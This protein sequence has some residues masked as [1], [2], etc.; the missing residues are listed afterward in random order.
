MPGTK[1]RRRR[2]LVLIGILTIPL[3]LLLL[4]L[5]LWFP[6]LAQPAARSFGFEF[7]SYRRLGLTRFELTGVTGR[8]QN[9]HITVGR[10]ESF[11]PHRW[12]WERWNLSSRTN[13]YA[14][15]T[16]WSVQIHPRAETEPARPGAQSTLQLLDQLDQL[17][18]TLRSWMPAAQ[19]RRGKIHFLDRTAALPEV[20]W[21]VGRLTAR[22][23]APELTETVSVRL[24]AT[25]PGRWRTEIEGAA[26]GLNVLAELLRHPNAWS[27]KGALN[28]HSN[29]VAVTARFNPGAWL[30]VEAQLS[31]QELRLPPE[32]N[33]L[34][35]YGQCHGGFLLRWRDEAYTLKAHG[36]AE[37]LSS[38]TNQIWP[39][40]ELDLNAHGDLRSAMVD[41][42][43]VRAS[44]FTLQLKQPMTLAYSASIIAKPGQFEAN[45]NLDRL[46]PDWQGRLT[47]EIGVRP[48]TNHYP[49]IAIRMRSSALAA[50]GIHA[51]DL[52]ARASFDWPLLELEAARMFLGSN[53]TAQAHGVLDLQTR[54]LRTAVFE[55]QGDDLRQFLPDTLGVD[56]LTARVQAAGPLSHLSHHG[57]LQVNQLT[58]PQLNPLAL[59]LHWKGEGLESASCGAQLQA[60]AARLLL[61]GQIRR[62]D[63]SFASLEARLETLTLERN[64][65]PVYQLADATRLRW[66][67]DHAPDW[68]LQLDPLVWKN[69]NDQLLSLSGA[70]HWPTQGQVQLLAHGL[71]L[72]EA[73]DFWP[74]SERPLTLSDLNLTAG[75][76]DGPLHWQVKGEARL[77]RP[78]QRSLEI[79]AH[80]RGDGSGTYVES[81]TL[82]GW[83]APPLVGR[84]VLPVALDLAE[85][86]F[87]RLLPDAPLTFA[88]SHEPAD[89]ISV[90][91]QQG[92][93][94]ELSRPA[95]DLRVTGTARQPRGQLRASLGAATYRPIQGAATLPRLEHARIEAEFQPGLIQLKRLEFQLDDQPIAVHG[96]WPLETNAW[97]RL[98]SERT[99]PDWQAASG[100][101]RIQEADLAPVAQHLPKL[102]ASEGKLDLDLSLRPGLVLDGFLSL[103]NAM[104]R[105]LGPLAPVREIDLL[106]AFSGRTARVD[107]FAGRLGGQLVH[108]SGHA[109]LSDT[110]ELLYALRLQ[111][112]NAPLVREPG[113]LLRADLDLTLEKRSGQDPALAG[114]VLLRDGLLLQDVSSLLVDRLER[115]ALRPPY[116]SVTNLP[117]GRW[118]LNVKVTGDRFLR[119]R[120]PAFIGAVSAD[121]LV[122]G[123]LGRPVI[124]ADVRIPNGR[125]LFPFGKL[126]VEG[127]YATVSGEE[128]RGP[129]IDLIAA[130]PNYNYNVRLEVAGTLDDLNVLFTSTPPL[131]SE[132]I[133]LM[134]T[135][136][137][138]P[139]QEITYSA[140]A[141]AGRLI[142]YLGR[143]VATRFF[144]NEMSE[145]RLIINSGENIARSGRTTYSI[146]YLLTP[147]WSLVGEYDEFNAF[148]AGLKW[149]IYSK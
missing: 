87:I 88:V 67:Q 105:P 129:R 85:A 28:W 130:G 63:P 93:R 97:T 58:V 57:E 99:L 20:D 23:E 113:L 92:D 31:G 80:V 17:A 41:T 111:G 18:Q 19:L 36:Q 40:L 59:A 117:F 34:P 95:F 79:G 112:T 104:T 109:A 12:L 22:L 47:A 149:R 27:L 137:D 26:P 54:T 74:E 77:D 51:N 133:L 44:W 134:L 71:P 73:R 70:V 3:G 43:E 139:N 75:W 148:N 102:L 83:T 9:V 13:L 39:S 125:I 136:G 131:S 50:G 68:Q 135:A 1:S 42:L 30:P 94:L 61:E 76:T 53:S 106:V 38:I 16:D 144:G 147:R 128:P 114:T 2:F 122:Q 141:R 60:G 65:L 127:A 7:E 119:V 69:S 126:N 110:G 56:G 29:R 35:H 46:D 21:S 10:L 103:T 115:P 14:S 72:S 11:L 91:L 123:S 89:A 100:H 132:D 120:S 90:G 142:T 108:A 66:Q 146:E 82:K 81:L 107:R 25:R 5:P 96:E 64:G 78:E 52:E 4:C 86:G 24:E 121:A 84:G 143:E 33:G 138:L 8:I 140:Q 32:F 118:D 145:E 124:K 101:V 15:A 55:W 62:P 45:A 49:A 37:P 6:W 116:F 48:G 98:I